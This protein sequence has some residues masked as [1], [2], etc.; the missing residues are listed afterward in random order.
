M[1]FC[2]SVY[3][4]IKLK[5]K[6]ETIYTESELVDT[7]SGS[8]AEKCITSILEV[9]RFRNER[10]RTLCCDNKAS[11]ITDNYRRHIERDSHIYIYKVKHRQVQ[12]GVGKG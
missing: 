10:T 12:H 4:N 3:Y 9:F 1:V 6:F 7:V 8:K 5:T 11:I 2:A